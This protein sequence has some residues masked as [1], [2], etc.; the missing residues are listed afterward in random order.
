V[1]ALLADMD[2]G[3]DGSYLRRDIRDALPV[4]P[5][6]Y[7]ERQCYLGSSIFS[8]AEIDGRHRIGVGKM[9]LGQ[10]YPHHEGT[11]H[12]GTLRYLQATLGA[13][14]VAEDEARMMLGETAATVF[15]F[16]RTALA[17]FTNRLAVTVHDVLRPPNEVFFPRGDVNKPFV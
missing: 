12:S 11:V 8:R 5:S 16:D 2:Y 9:M 1:A 17:P 13:A 6:E 3:Y 7:F 10:D 14:S 15:G 4:R